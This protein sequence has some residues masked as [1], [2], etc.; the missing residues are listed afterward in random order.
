MAVVIKGMDMPKNCCDCILFE[1]DYYCRLAN[2]MGVYHQ[3]GRMKKCPL[4]EIPDT[5]C[6]KRMKKPTRTEVLSSLA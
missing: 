5:D 6:G 4:V 2:D 3:Q 1:E